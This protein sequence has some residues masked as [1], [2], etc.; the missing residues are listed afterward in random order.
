MSRTES[1]TENVNNI[2][3]G[4]TTGTGLVDIEADDGKFGCKLHDEKTKT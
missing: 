4:E 1:K 2:N 3:D